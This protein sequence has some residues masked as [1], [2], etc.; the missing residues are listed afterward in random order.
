MPKK[1]FTLN[2]FSGG[3]VTDKS[4]RA[5]ENN[6]LAECTNF[7]VS[8]KGKIIASRIFKQTTLYGEGDSTG[9][10]TDPG[11]GLTTFSNDFLSAVPETVNIGEFV[12]FT[13]DDNELDLLEVTITGTDSDAWDQDILTASSYPV[14]ERQAFYAAEGDLFVGGTDDSSSPRFIT[15]TSYVF[16]KQLQIPTWTHDVGSGQTNHTSGLS[17]GA[18]TSVYHIIHAA[19]SAITL[20]AKVTGTGIPDDTHITKIVDSTHSHINKAPTATATGLTFSFYGIGVHKWSAGTQDK[21]IP[22]GTVGTPSA[23]GQRIWQA[24]SDNSTNNVLSSAADIMHWVI[25]PGSGGSGLWTNDQSSTSAVHEFMGTW[26]YKN[27]T[28]SDM[29]TLHTGNSMTGAADFGLTDATG[30]YVQSWYGGGAT[31]TDAVPVTSTS[32]LIYGARL[33]SR[34]AGDGGDYYLLAEMNMEKGIKGDGETEWH[35]WEAASDEFDHN[36]DTGDT[37][38][39]GLIAAP[40]ALLTYKLLN[41]FSTDDIPTDSRRVDFKSGLIANSRAYI[42]NVSINGRTYGD[43]ILKSPVFQY[44]VFTEDNYLDVAINDG[45]QIT[46]LAAHGDRILQ[47]KNSAVYIINVSKELEFLEDEQQSAGVA[48]Q[49]AVTTTPFGVVW[50]NTNGCY[51]YDGEKIA[52]LQLGKLSAT[53]WENVTSLATI[54]YDSERQQVIVL[55]SSNNGTNAFVFDAET[56]GWHKVSDMVD[57]TKNTTNMTNARGDKLLIGGGA[58]INYVNFLADRTA[59]AAGFS[60]KTKVLDLGNPES[61]KNLLEVAVVYRFGHANLDV[62][63][64]TWDDG[65]TKTATTVGAISVDDTNPDTAQ[66]DTSGTAALQGNKVYQIEISGTSNEDVEITSISLVYRD[67]GVH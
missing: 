48:F 46:A 65:G 10:E 60:F 4:D 43:R 28:E 34:F 53:D 49:A 64:N 54:G 42:G 47:F 58:D 23:P 14:G 38:T 59:A 51:H 32:E 50:V 63:I 22:S 8:S 20:G 13:G 6:E 40:P 35:A 31:S 44:D 66:F 9:A 62:I 18:T 16:H 56:G 67:L 24:T 37:A 11:Y 15:P 3:L 5:L 1:V 2:D 52:Q 36:N 33:Y 45:D 21:P 30:L 25:K 17:D 29:F 26:L 55:W 7:D 12:V 27:D 61:K 41:G 57:G 19:S 39:T